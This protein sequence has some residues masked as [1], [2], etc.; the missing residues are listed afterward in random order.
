M[1]RAAQILDINDLPEVARLAREVAANH[2]RVV[3]RDGDRDVAVITPAQPAR[4]RGRRISQSDIEA[5]LGTAGAWEGLVDFD[6]LKRELR[7]A[8]WDDRPARSP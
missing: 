5:A 7:E 6:Q 4:R 2:Q 1:V 8:Q 3:L